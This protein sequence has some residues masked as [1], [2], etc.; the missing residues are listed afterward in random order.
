M[1][2]ALP[3]GRGEVVAL[4]GEVALGEVVLC[5]EVVVLGAV[6]CYRCC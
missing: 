6:Q 3:G 2:L 4:R 5:A 1:A